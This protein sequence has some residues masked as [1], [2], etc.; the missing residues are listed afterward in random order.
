VR[1]CTLAVCIQARRWRLVRAN[2]GDQSSQM[3][4]E[5]SFFFVAVRRRAVH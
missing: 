2:L 3:E 5:A 4:M 1:A